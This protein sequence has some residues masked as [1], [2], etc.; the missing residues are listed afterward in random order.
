MSISLAALMKCV[1]KNKQDPDMQDEIRRFD[2]K[3]N[4]PEFVRGLLQACLNTDRKLADRTQRT[5]QQGV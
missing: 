1:E 2:E 3:M 4:D 5:Q